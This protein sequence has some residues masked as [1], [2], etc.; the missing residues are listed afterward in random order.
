MN[1]SSD[2]INGFSTAR[3]MLAAL[4]A[5][6]ISAVEL[7]ELHLGRIARHNPALNAVVIRND[8]EARR[9]AAEADA[10]RTRGEEAPLLGLPM[11]VKD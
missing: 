10:R 5:R 6:R 11:T 8:E 7:L 3:E 2:R 9:L 1:T 4:R